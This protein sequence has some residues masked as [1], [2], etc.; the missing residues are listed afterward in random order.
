MSVFQQLSARR[1]L[2]VADITNALKAGE[3]TVEEAASLLDHVKMSVPRSKRQ[4]ARPIK[5]Q[6]SMIDEA[7]LLTTPRNSYE[8]LKRELSGSE[9]IQSY[10][11]IM[12]L[13]GVS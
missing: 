6:L 7:W 11:R 10:Q 12:E 13:R 8:G 2:D 4:Q 1:S 3:I 9:H 5:D